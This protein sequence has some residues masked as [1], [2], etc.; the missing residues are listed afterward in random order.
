[1]AVVNVALC[2]VFL[3]DDVLLMPFAVEFLPGSRRSVFHILRIDCEN[4][5]CKLEQ[6]RDIVRLPVPDVLLDAF[7]HIHAGLLALYDHQGNAV[8]QKDNIRPGKLPV[9]PF[10]GKLVGHLPDVLFRVRPVDIGN[11]EGLNIPVI[12][13]YF[14]AFPVDQ[15]IIDHLAGEHK[16][17]LQGHVQLPDCLSDGLVGEGR[18]FSAVLEGLRRQKLPHDVWKQ[19]A[20]KVPAL[21]LRLCPGNILISH[22]LQLPQGP[23]LGLR[24]LVE[25]G[26]TWHSASLQ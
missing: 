21:L 16:T 5:L 9:E 14:T 6:L 20:G 25:N 4:K 7:L 23:V 15:P 22:C 18:L 12:Q 1:M 3:P 2:G 17:A 11:V 13:M 24:T 10:H 26:M 8:H 19:H